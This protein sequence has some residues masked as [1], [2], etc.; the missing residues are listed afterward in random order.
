MCCLY[1]FVCGVVVLLVCLCVG[2]FVSVDAVFCVGLFVLC[3]LY[4]VSLF[5]LLVLCWC[6]EFFCVGLSCFDLL[7]YVRVLCV[8]IFDSSS[9]RVLLPLFGY[10]YLPVYPRCCIGLYMSVC[11]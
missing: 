4:I 6:S 5:V 10:F 11:V 7:C 8:V 9:H 1:L 2:L 3:V